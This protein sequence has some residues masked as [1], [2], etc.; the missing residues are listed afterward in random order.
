MLPRLL[1]HFYCYAESRFS[2]PMVSGLAAY[3]MKRCS[4][5]R[6]STGCGIR[7]LSDCAKT[8]ILEA[9]LK[10]MPPKAE[11]RTL[12]YAVKAGRMPFEVPRTRV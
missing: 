9:W 6:K 12:R 4:M 10:S 3:A 5:K 2:N 11:Y 7:S 1:S 8:R